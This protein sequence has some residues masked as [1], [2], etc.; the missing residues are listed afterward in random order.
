MKNRGPV[1][2]TLFGVPLTRDPVAPYCWSGESAGVAISY[3]E[4]RDAT[5]WISVMVGSGP[6]Y[7]IYEGDG[8]NRDEAVVS[9]RR[10][11]ERQEAGAAA[12]RRLLEAG[13]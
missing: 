5:V 7:C 8:A 12:F 2:V 1:V 4:Y 6:H 10:D 3:H 9:L 11:L 13:L